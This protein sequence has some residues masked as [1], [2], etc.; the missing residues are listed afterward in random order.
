MEP[1]PQEEF[2]PQVA[3]AIAALAVLAIMWWMVMIAAIGLGAMHLSYCPVQPN[4]PIFLIVF[5]AASLLTLCL[6]STKRTWKDGAVF[7]LWSTFTTL[8]HV[9]CFCWFIAGSVWV[10]S[11]YPPSYTPGEDQYC[12]KITFQFAFAVITFTWVFLSLVIVSSCCVAVLMCCTTITA[13]QHLIP[14]RNSSYGATS[15]SAEPVAG[16]V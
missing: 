6:T 16:D 7:M 5:G 9:F 11:V 14:N 2:T 8:L 13:S 10:Y 4:I 12:H 15:H 3:V 1:S